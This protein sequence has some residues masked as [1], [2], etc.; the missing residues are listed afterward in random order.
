[1]AVFIFQ[2]NALDLIAQVEGVRWK[3]LQENDR[4]SSYGFFAYLEAYREMV[5]EGLEDARPSWYLPADDPGDGAIYGADGCH[6]YFVA[7]SGEIIFS[8]FHSVESGRQREAGF[9]IR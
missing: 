3:K 5:E 1:M 6:R 4:N 8:G 2:E 9:S 7:G